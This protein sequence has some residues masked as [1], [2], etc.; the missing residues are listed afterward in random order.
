ME[1][2]S[3]EE[4]EDVFDETPLSKKNLIDYMSMSMLK[5]MEAMEAKKRHRMNEHSVS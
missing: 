1:E 5:A 3:L 2:I 4:Q